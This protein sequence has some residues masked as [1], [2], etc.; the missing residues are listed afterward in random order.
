ML[1]GL[2]ENKARHFGELSSILLETK[3]EA[4]GKAAN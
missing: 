1:T 4:E 3:A 2:N